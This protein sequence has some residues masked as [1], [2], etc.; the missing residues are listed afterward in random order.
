ML[1]KQDNIIT[2]LVD[3]TFVAKLTKICQIN[4]VFINVL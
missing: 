3:M 4:V 1:I 2:F